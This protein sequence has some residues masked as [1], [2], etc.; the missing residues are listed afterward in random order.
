M[1]ARIGRKDAKAQADAL[2]T[3]AAT[4]MAG[5]VR[6]IL[7]SQRDFQAG[8]GVGL[9]GVGL[10]FV[11]QI[12]KPLKCEV[13]NSRSVERELDFFPVRAKLDFVGGGWS[14]L[15]SVSRR[16]KRHGPTRH[17]GVWLLFDKS[18]DGIL[19]SGVRSRHREFRSQESVSDYRLSVVRRQWSVVEK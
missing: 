9:H 5:W 3:D 11:I 17:S 8:Y 7:S 6:E 19:N 1:R 4:I 18:K 14:S 10:Q 16:Q 13:Q 12:D 15:I 2:L